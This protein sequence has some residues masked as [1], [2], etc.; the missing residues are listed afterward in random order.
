MIEI[1]SNCGKKNN[2]RENSTE[3]SGRWKCGNCGEVINEV[4]S[5]SN[6]HMVLW[7]IG[8]IVVAN[9]IAGYFFFQKLSGIERKYN[10]EISSIKKSARE[11]KIKHDKEVVSITE[12]VNSALSLQDRKTKNNKINLV[13]KMDNDLA[14]TSSDVRKIIAESNSRFNKEFGLRFVNINQKF[15][16]F[17]KQTNTGFETTDKNLEKLRKITLELNDMKRFLDIQEDNGVTMIRVDD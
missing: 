8:I 13:K 11:F 3:C 7:G 17:Y 10:N 14:K 2:I 12:E 6:S 15:L 5:M 16:E 1:C 9:A 4:N